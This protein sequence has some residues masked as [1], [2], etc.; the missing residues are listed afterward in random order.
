MKSYAYLYLSAF[1]ARDM[2]QTRAL[3]RIKTQ[4]LYTLTFSH[5]RAVYEIREKIWYRQTDRS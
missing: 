4:V 5:N 2:F 3:E 1:L